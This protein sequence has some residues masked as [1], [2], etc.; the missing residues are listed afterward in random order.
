M[1]NPAVVPF[2]VTGAEY[3]TPDER[4][5]AWRVVLS[6]SPVPIGPSLIEGRTFDGRDDAT[7]LTVALVSRELAREQWPGKS[8][9]GETI[10][11]ATGGAAPERRVVVGV[12]GDV[13]FDPVG[14]VAAGNSAVYVPFP[15]APLPSTR[16]IVR[17]SGEEAA[18]H[19]AMYEALAR[20]DPTIAPNIQTY[21]SAI[22]SLTRF[23]RAITQ[24][25]AGCGVFAIMLAI[26]GIYGMSSNAVV[27][28][29]HEIGLRRAL[30]ATNRGIIGLFVK[31]S[32][33]QLTIGLS[34]SA[35]LSVVVLAVI[36]QSFTIGAGELA[37]IGAGVISVISATVLVSV[38]FSVHSAIRL[39]PSSAL[40]QG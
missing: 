30:G 28:R 6:E 32:A 9:L 4:P 14:M 25:F 17:H 34:L 8:P 24:L 16:F 2:A 35:V 5:T 39:D 21:D 10:E 33:R 37:V 36:R 3:A 23:A 31:Q 1:S 29:T 40:R 18:A 22:E 7:G 19:G 27:L 12:V 38:Y 26:T 13:V 11:V 20:V 15:Q